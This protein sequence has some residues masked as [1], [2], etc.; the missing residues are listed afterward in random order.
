M[1]PDDPVEHSLPTEIAAGLERI[2]SRPASEDSVQKVL[3]AA[4]ALGSEDVS[5]RSTS[6][7]AP[8]RVFAGKLVIAL[9]VVVLLSVG[10]LTSRSPVVWADVV[11]SMEDVPWLKLTP[12]DSTIEFTSWLS[13]SRRIVG[14]RHR[15]GADFVD[16]AA[17]EHVEFNKVNGTLCRIPV[18]RP[19]WPALETIHEIITA[20]AV[21]S[22]SIFSGFKVVD[23]ESRTVEVS[24]RKWIEFVLQLRQAATILKMT[25]RVD[26]ESQLPVWLDIQGDERTTRFEVSYPDDGPRDIYALGAP[27]DLKITDR[28]PSKDLQVVL[29]KLNT[30]FWEFGDYAAIV[31]NER[32][33][34]WRLIRRDGERWRFDRCVSTD[35]TQPVPEDNA[36][37]LEV[38]GDDQWWKDR[39]SKFDLLPVFVCDGETVYRFTDKGERVRHRRG[40]GDSISGMIETTHFLIEWFAW[41]PHKV[42]SEFTHRL[43]PADDDGPD[44]TLLL[45]VQAVVPPSRSLRFRQCKLWLDPDLDYAVVRHEMLGYTDLK[46]PGDPYGH[47]DQ[48]N[49]LR[50]FSEFRKSP[51]GHS[52]PTVVHWKNV[53]NKDGTGKAHDITTYY[54]LD[55]ET[56]IPDSV[57]R[58]GAQPTD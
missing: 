57:F 34:P 38:T 13:P 53:S 32:G 48:T 42:N 36:R 15:D 27:R 21:E 14:V 50:E 58:V 49:Q 54:H 44:G 40:G 51:A 28:L 10:L 43:G 31:C 35:R 30:A 3:L 8:R 56:A 25:V 47:L 41:P 16:Q 2:R 1:K 4:Q 6:K 52:Y 23:Q 46:L 29:E 55:F 22:G 9:T 37:L 7:P 17:G 24:G 39:L 26:P 20:G 45:D 12:T 11:Q 19:H 5:S 18:D 33:V